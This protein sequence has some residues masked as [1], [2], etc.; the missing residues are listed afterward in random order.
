M[1]VERTTTIS[2][3]EA[4]QRLLCTHAPVTFHGHIMKGLDFSH[5]EVSGVYFAGILLEDTSFRNAVC[6][7]ASFY[8]SFIENCD[9][10]GADLSRAVFRGSKISGCNF[11]SIKAPIWKKVYLWLK[12][13]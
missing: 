2:Q 7:G 9:F 10:T 6:I 5:R 13:S 1:S 3:D 12:N 11:S 4:N 8:S